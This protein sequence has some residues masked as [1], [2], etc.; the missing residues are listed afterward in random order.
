MNPG[1]AGRTE[2]PDNLKALFRPMSMM[3]PDYALVAEVMLFSEGFEDS[4]VLSR[5]MV[6]LYKL[7][8]E[9]VSQQDHYDFGMRAVK[10]VLVM[11]G[12]LKRANPDLPEDVV[13]IRAMRDSNLPKFLVHDMELFQNIIADLFPGVHVPSQVG[14]WLVL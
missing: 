1:Y 12:G 2:L 14:C 11:A 8:S 9:Q 6:K 3:I 13:L 7:A 4:K 10:S 5:K